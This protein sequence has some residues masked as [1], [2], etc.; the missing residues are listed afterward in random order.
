MKKFLALL[1]V[2]VLC[3]SLAGCGGKDKTPDPADYEFVITPQ[4][5]SELLSDYLSSESYL[6]GVEASGTNS[7]ALLEKAMEYHLADING[8]SI[9]GIVLQLRSD[10][11]YEDGVFS[12]PLVF[13]D[14]N[15]GEVSDNICAEFN[16]YINS[17]T[18]DITCYE[19]LRSVIMNCLFCNDNPDES[20]IFHHYESKKLLTENEIASVNDILGLSYKGYESGQDADDSTDETGNPIISTDAQERMEKVIEM[21]SAFKETPFYRQVAIDPTSICVGAA[22]EYKNDNFSGFPVH[23]LLAYINYVDIEQYGFT[24]GTLLMDMNTGAIY[25]HADFDFNRLANFNSFSS[26]ED[27][28]P[29]CMLSYESI[30]L[31]YESQLWSSVGET[32]I[33]LTEEEL[34]QINDTLSSA[35]AAAS[36]E[37]DALREEAA[38]NLS[39]TQKLF[40]D[41]AV[42]FSKTSRYK[43]TAKNP[44]SI[45]IANASEF[46]FVHP[47]N[48]FELNVI[49]LQ[50][51]GIDA[52][53]YG[54]TA[55][56]YLKD[57]KT[58]TGCTDTFTDLS[59]WT[60]DWEDYSDINN[61]YAACILC[62]EPVLTNGEKHLF[63]DDPCDQLTHLSKAD[64]DAINAALN[65]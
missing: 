11:A 61:V 12:A 17:Y 63:M 32:M 60:W 5:V 33:R 26:V 58:G 8:F 4:Y 35:D 7:G 59:S 57:R 37:Q 2:T 45:R 65:P 13:I 23:I 24:A 19:Q 38:K 51:E 10:V 21:A 50:A 64:L 9:D 34:S 31:R 44:A 3:I 48:G 56:F 55:G 47:D 52:D 46:S 6:K 22:M 25:S 28:Y 18:S 42:E 53:M 1:L 41:A 14:L 30:L 36:A 16:E 27:A 20:T 15:T 29:H 39:D 43:E 40:F 54:L 62:Y 49:L